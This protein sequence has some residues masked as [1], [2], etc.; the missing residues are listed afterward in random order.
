MTYAYADQ[1]T[2][3][4][5]SAE[6]V[7]IKELDMGARLIDRAVLRAIDFTSGEHTVLYNLPKSGTYYLHPLH[8]SKAHA[9]FSKIELESGEVTVMAVHKKLKEKIV[10]NE[11]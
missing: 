4:Y 11:S 2:L 1:D 8:S 6:D 7:Q 3:F 9:L 5:F 10:F